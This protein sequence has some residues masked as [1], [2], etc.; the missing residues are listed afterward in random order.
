L[1]QDVACDA[2]NVSGFHKQIAPDV[3][4]P[5]DVLFMANARWL[6]VVKA[7]NCFIAANAKVFHASN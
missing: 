3:L 1:N 6:F 2:V 4:K 5:M 7:T